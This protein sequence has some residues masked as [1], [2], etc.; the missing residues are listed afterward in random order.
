MRPRIISIAVFS[1]V[2]VC[3]SGHDC[4]SATGSDALLRDTKARSFTDSIARDIEEGAASKLQAKM[5]SD[6]QGAF[7]Q[8]Q[9]N[10]RFQRILNTYGHLIAYEYKNTAAGIKLLPDGKKKPM[11]RL[12]Y[13]VIT[14]MH[15]KGECFLF[16]EIVKEGSA[17][18]CSGFSFTTF[19]YG[20]PAELK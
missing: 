19:P 8:S 20:V 17:L 9:F 12:W 18:A 16:I 11:K 6:L 3:F 5:T 13:S 2:V 14:S 4:C 7:T 15:K 1:L 10:E